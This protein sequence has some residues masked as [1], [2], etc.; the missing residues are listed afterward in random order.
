MFGFGKSE[1]EKESLLGIP[2][3]GKKYG[4]LRYS[5][6]KMSNSSFDLLAE[7]VARQKKVRP[8]SV[9]VSTMEKEMAL[10]KSRRTLYGALP[11]V[12]AFGMKSREENLRRVLSTKTLVDD[13]EQVLIDTI[14]SLET[15]SNSISCF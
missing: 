4:A 3:G 2:Y 1:G 14:Y 6:G 9:S 12:A 11:F 7:E 10:D 5:T 8:H 13:E 15:V